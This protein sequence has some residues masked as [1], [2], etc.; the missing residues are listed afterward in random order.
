MKK[1]TKEPDWLSW[2]GKSWTESDG[3]THRVSE[4][5]PALGTITYQVIV[6]MPITKTKLHHSVRLTPCEAT[7]ATMK[8]YSK[9]AK[10]TL[11]GLM[12]KDLTE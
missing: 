3:T 5:Q 12:L 2:Q 11:L 8:R 7:N 9:V 1:K 10:A 4:Y 6:T